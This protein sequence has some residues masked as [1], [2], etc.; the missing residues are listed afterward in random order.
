M[1]GGAVL[2]GLQHSRVKRCDAAAD[3]QGVNTGRKG[4]TAGVRAE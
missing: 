1:I 3:A 4:D 2:S